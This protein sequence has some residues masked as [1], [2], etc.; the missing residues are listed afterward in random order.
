MKLNELN[1]T[2]M[3]E[4]RYDSTFYFVSFLSPLN[5]RLRAQLQQAT[6]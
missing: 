2:D 4:T 1:R 6:V 3:K 5:V